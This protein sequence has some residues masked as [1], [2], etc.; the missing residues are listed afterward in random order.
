MVRRLS[1]SLVE[2]R[3]DYLVVRTPASPNFWWGNFLLMPGPPSFVDADRWES[4]FVAEFPDLHHRAFGIDTSD[5]KAGT[6]EALTALGASA[7][8]NAVM[9]STKMREPAFSDLDLR[10]FDD[11]D[12]AQL[13]TLRSAV[14]PRA[15]TANADHEA[16]FL[17]QQVAASQDLVARGHGEWLGAFDRGLLVATLGIVSVGS[18]VARYQW[19]ETHPD[20]RRRGLASRLIYDAAALASDRFDAREVVI[21]ADPEEAAFRLYESLGFVTVERQVELTRAEGTD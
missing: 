12:W 18:G 16:E 1:G 4:W 5:G 11:A 2:S 20:Y 7:Q 19:V 3:A 13:A 10:A 8:V 21:V 6:P 15:D 17:A 14:Y 9:S